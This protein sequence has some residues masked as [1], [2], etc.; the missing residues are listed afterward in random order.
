MQNTIALFVALAGPIAN[1]LVSE[2]CVQE[3][4]VPPEVGDVAPPLGDLYFYQRGPNHADS[5]EAL[6]GSVVLVHTYF[7]LCDP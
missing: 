6:R 2:A 4:H 3:E 7:H 5:L 1:S